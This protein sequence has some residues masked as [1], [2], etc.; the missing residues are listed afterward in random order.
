MPDFSRDIFNVQKSLLWTASV[1]SLFVAICTSEG[2]TIE[3]A[4]AEPSMC[5]VAADALTEAARLRGLAPTREV[6]CVVRSVGEIEQFLRD[7][8]AA[9]FPRNLLVM[10]E[11]VYQAI[12]VVPDDYPYAD[13]IIQAYVSQIG[14]Y[15]DPDKKTFVM[16]DTMAANMQ[17]PVAVHE[18]THALQDQHFGLVDFLD[19]KHKSDE[20]M[21]HAALVEG[22]ATAIMQRSGNHKRSKMS[23]ASARSSDTPEPLE[24]P[25]ALER[26]LLFPYIE[27]LSF[28]R[29][30]EK[31]GG[32]RRINR[33]FQDPPRSSREILHPTEYL[34]RQ[35]PV[36]VPTSASLQ[37]GG[38]K[39]VFEHTDSLGEF[40]IM[41]MLEA[42][43]VQKRV[44]Q[45]AAQG[46]RGDLIGVSKRDAGGYDVVW[47][48]V[49]DSREDAEDFAKQ[50][51]DF[52][53]RRYQKEVG[54]NLIQV[55]GDKM[56]KRRLALD[57]ATV[58][59]NAVVTTSP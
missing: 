17:Y 21:A 41:A 5:A 7:T 47:R 18:L 53:Y 58:V 40:T 19:P 48:T 27:G 32:Q 35:N 46:L 29:A 14:G 54:D 45:R 20:L 57:D 4:H 8:L 26:I 28:V 33:S 55:A 9:K 6:P 3:S 1:V 51:G 23:E 24:V 10:E 16:V 44:A 2:G 59:I 31:E 15:Y 25:E 12:G 37:E 13:R 38:V 43:G 36:L 56:M 39:R 42:G 30:L 22:D 50:Y 49:W 52:L 34:K 11:R